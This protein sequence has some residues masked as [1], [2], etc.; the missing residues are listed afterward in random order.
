MIGNR[1]GLRE[2][3]Q[4]AESCRALGASLEGLGLGCLVDFVWFKGNKSICAIVGTNTELQK[5][6]E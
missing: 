2:G 5:T 1:T 6:E 4:L 3:R